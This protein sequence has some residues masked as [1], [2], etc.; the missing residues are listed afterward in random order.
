MGLKDSTSQITP[1]TNA[2]KPR[3]LESIDTQA[4]QVAPTR[5]NHIPSKTDD[6]DI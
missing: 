3:N 1:V 2:H 5:I 4:N 6:S